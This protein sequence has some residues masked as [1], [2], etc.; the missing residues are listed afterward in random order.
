MVELVVTVQRL[1]SHSTL[2]VTSNLLVICHAVSNV[3][4]RKE[5]KRKKAV[6][7]ANLDRRFGEGRSGGTFDVFY[8][9]RAC[10]V[11]D[12]VTYESNA[13]GDVVVLSTPS[14]IVENGV[15][16]SGGSRHLRNDRLL[17]L[18]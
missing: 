15:L 12:G 13:M 14:V 6:K 2:G 7:N 5:G 10:P 1:E 9:S 3:A 8:V 17:I 4:H 18:F 11:H 16:T